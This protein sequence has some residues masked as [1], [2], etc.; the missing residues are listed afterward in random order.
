LV[1]IF[2]Q[3][4][5]STQRQDDDLGRSHVLFASG[6]VTCQAVWGTASE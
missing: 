4:F 3:F 5:L 6:T 1:Y 2:L